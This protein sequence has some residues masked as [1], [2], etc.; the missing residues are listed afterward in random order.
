MAHSLYFFVVEEAQGSSW[1]VTLLEFHLW[2]QVLRE[3]DLS[4]LSLGGE[5][6]QGPMQPLRMVLVTGPEN[7]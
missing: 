7:D 2:S 3:G 4:G 5:K 1:Y 6:Q